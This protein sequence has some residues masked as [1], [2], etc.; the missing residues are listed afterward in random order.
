MA[1]GKDAGKVLVSA[2]VGAGAGAIVAAL[3][4]RRPAAA[5]PPDEKID[6]MLE[7]LEQIVQ[8][9]V[10]IA[11]AIQQLA[12][13]LQAIVPVIPEVVSVSTPWVGKDPE[14]ILSQAVR[15]IGTFYSDYMVDYT[16]SKRLLIKVES[17]LDQAVNI[18]LI[19]NISD[20]R[21]L[22]TNVGP[23]FPCV[24][25]GNISIG[26][27]WDDWHPFIGVEI[28]AAIAPTTGILNIWAVVQE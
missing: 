9:N 24:A 6:Y 19:G 2:G 23:V 12:Q 1:E 17:S 25:N 26:L 11:A 14:H 8:G 4:A 22:A 16:K 21:L 20:T 27:A 18:Q 13:A 3:L 15:A 7:L 5:A 28:T 10:A